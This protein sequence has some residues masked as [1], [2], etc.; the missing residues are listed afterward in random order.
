MIALVASLS[1]LASACGA[2][3]PNDPRGTTS[4]VEA[5]GT[6]RL[7]VIDAPPYAVAEGPG[8]VSGPEVELA[9]GYAERYGATVVPVTG[10]AA[11]LFS[12]LEHGGLHMVVGGISTS[13]PWSS[14]VAL[15]RPYVTVGKDRLAFA[16]RKGENGFLTAL[17]RYLRDEADAVVSDLVDRE[18]S[19]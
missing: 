19:E 12:E 14:K 4:Q 11:E 13:N 7:G 6:L 16:V 9:R 3:F 17:E 10:T 15:T 2:S 1:I 18:G 5:S 8:D